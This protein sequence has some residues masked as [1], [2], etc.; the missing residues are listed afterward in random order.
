MRW[1]ETNALG[2]VG[3]AGYLRYLVETA[4]DWGASGGL[5]IAESDALG[6]AWIVHEMDLRLYRP[7]L[8]EDLFDFSIW[9]VDWRRVRG[10]RCFEL[11]LQAGH[12]RVAR[13][14]QQVVALD[15][16]TL[17]PARVPEHLMAS[18]I[19]ENPRVFDMP[20]F[21]AGQPRAEST[22]AA[23]RT[24]EWRDI[25][26]QEHV[27][28][29]AYAEFA[30]Q[31][32]VGAFAAAGWPPDAFKAQGLAVINRRFHIQY[33]APA[34]WGDVLDVS[35]SLLELNPRGGT[36][37]IE[38][39]RASTGDLISRCTLEW[40]AVDRAGGQVQPLPQTLLQALQA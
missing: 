1:S 29:A 22:F 25:D 13:G 2:Q 26:M 39:A 12:E 28:N 5:G 31:T 34:Q 18:F 27:N 11:R 10:T 33:K 15:A 19:S 16:Q 40:S 14:A 36:W 7:L 9:L 21:P 38:M 37:L 30:E 6:L 4:W 24:I 3:L 17:R 32:A 35:A 8:P 20:K 23:Q